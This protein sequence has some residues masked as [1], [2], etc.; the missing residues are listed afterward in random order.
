LSRERAIRTLLHAKYPSHFYSR[1]ES[2]EKGGGSM[3]QT[4]AGGVFLI[5]L[6]QL[7]IVILS[8]GVGYTGLRPPNPGDLAALDTYPGEDYKEITDKQ[9]SALKRIPRSPLFWVAVKGLLVSAV[10]SF[11]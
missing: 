10:L 11:T 6:I 7:M 8:A 4:V 5:S 1:D 3:L 9:H 2:L